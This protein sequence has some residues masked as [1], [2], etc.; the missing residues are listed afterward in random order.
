MDYILDSIILTY[1]IFFFCCIK[2]EW[3]FATYKK[4]IILINTILITD[5][6]SR[7]FMDDV[8]K[9]K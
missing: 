5:G 8:H 2:L 3:L 7:M 6:G 9:Q 1:A 4:Y